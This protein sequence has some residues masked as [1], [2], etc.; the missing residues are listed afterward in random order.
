MTHSLAAIFDGSF[1][2]FD[3]SGLVLV[4]EGSMVYETVQHSYSTPTTLLQLALQNISKS[5]L[6]RFMT[7]WG[8]GMSLIARVHP[9]NVYQQLSVEAVRQFCSLLGNILHTIST[10]KTPLLCYNTI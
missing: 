5:F 8:R 4:C 6:L 1:L 2:N 9:L 10:L 7:L 3:L